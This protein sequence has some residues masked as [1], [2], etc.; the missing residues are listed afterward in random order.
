[1]EVCSQERVAHT[2]AAG[3]SR[4]CA[5]L[6]P[7][8]AGE[9]ELLHSRENFVEIER[10]LDLLLT[11]LCWT[12]LRGISTINKLEILTNGWNYYKQSM[13]TNQTQGR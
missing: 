2:W 7:F 6:N 5:K 4:V 1:M 8:G 13:E 12:D 10:A 11:G 3:A 9:I